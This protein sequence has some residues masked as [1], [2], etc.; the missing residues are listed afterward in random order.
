MPS[1]IGGSTGLEVDDF[2][3]LLITGTAEPRR[4]LAVRQ[5]TPARPAPSERL[6]LEGSS[7]PDSTA[8][9][10]SARRLL[11]TTAPFFLA[12]ATVLA[13]AGCCA[14]AALWLVD[15]VAAQA[16]GWLAPVT[17]LPMMAFYW[18]AGLYSE[19]WVHPVIELRQLTYVNTLVM[20]AAAAGSVL[21]GP[22]PVFFATG[23]LVVV[24]L[25]PMLRVMTR[26]A[27]ANCKWWG[28]P[29]LVIGC[30]KS[31]EHLT[32]TVLDA[33]HSGLRPVLAT[34]PDDRCR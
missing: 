15:P 9:S 17:L 34:D 23:W 25:L 13:L 7:L 3:D 8:L 29:T 20:L 5:M 32:R 14:T 33:P 1:T 2:E 16:I 31:V 10:M 24:P 28:F 4:E 26:H 21:A 11:R 6:D 22:F 27:C 19:L 30:D 12:D 18:L